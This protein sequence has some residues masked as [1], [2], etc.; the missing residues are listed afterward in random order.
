MLP[1]MKNLLMLKSL[2]T[3]T[4]FSVSFAVNSETPS[5]V[6]HKI[7]QWPVRPFLSVIRILLPHFDVR[8]YVR[9]G[10]G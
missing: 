2:E 4:T 10:G 8:I 9:C 6:G 3:S 5:G 7:S 1:E